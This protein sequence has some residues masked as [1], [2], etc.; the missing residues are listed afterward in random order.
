M[1]RLS[2]VLFF[3]FLVLGSALILPL[4]TMAAFTV[5]VDTNL[6]GDP[7]TIPGP[8]QQVYK[9]VGVIMDPFGRTDQFVEGEVILKSKDVNESGQFLQKWQG[10]ILSD[11]TIPAPSQEF[12][13]LQRTIPESN[14][15]LRIR[16][17]S[18]LV[19]TQQI[20]A[21]GTALGLDGMYKCSSLAMLQLFALFLEERVNNIMGLDL[22]GVFTL[23]DC[24]KT[25]TQEYAVDPSAPNPTLVNDGY[26]D[27]FTIANYNDPNISVTQAWQL[28]ELFGVGPGAVP[29]CVIDSGFT[30]T[31]DF[32]VFS[33]YDFVDDDRNVDADEAGYHGTRTL[34]VASARLDDQF[35]SAGT[36]GPVALPMP[37]RFDLTYSQGAR[38]IRT[39][40]SWG[41]EVINNSWGG[42]CD[43][44]CDTFG[45]LSGENA[46]NEALD[47][48]FDNGVVTV[49]AAGNSEDNLDDIYDL[50]SEGGAADKGNIV[51]GAL[52][53]ATKDSIQTATHGWG[54][55]FGSALD[56]WIA[57]WPRIL[58]TPTPSDTTISTIGRTSGASAYTAGVVALMKALAPTLT[59][60]EVHDM[61]DLSNMASTDPRVA[62]GYLNVFDA[63]HRAA[64][65]AGAID[66]PADTLEP[67]DHRDFRNISPGSYCANLYDGDTEDGYW[68]WVD[69]IRPVQVQESSLLL[70]NYTATLNGFALD[71]ELALP[72]NGEL[73]PGSYY[74]RFTKTTPGAAF[75]EFDLVIDA[76]STMTPDRFE[77]NDTLATAA[78]LT[79][80][81]NQIGRIWTI[82]SLNFHVSGDPDYF[83]LALPSLPSLLYTDRITIWV[84]P[85]ED[86]Y[87][88][89]FNLFL[90]DA[91]GAS[92]PATAGSATTI[93]NVRGTFTTGRIRFLVEDR[94]G[95]RNNY[96]ILIGYDQYVR[97]IAEPETFA[98]PD[99]PSWMPDPSDLFFIHIPELALEGLA[100]DFPYPSDPAIAKDIAEGNSPV[101]IPTEM[102]VLNW[103]QK[104]DFVME[105]RYTG[106]S[107]DM[108]FTL[109]DHNGATLAEATDIPMPLS[110]PADN[111][112]DVRKRI[113]IQAMERGIYGVR[114]NGGEKP[115][116]YSIKIEAA[117]VIP[118][119]SILMFVPAMLN[120]DK[121][122]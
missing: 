54:S 119:R 52:D 2:T 33:P 73:I 44:W 16:V 47:E 107:Q 37:F 50:P 77:V 81:G 51:V 118:S 87:S 110:M 120:G 4:S 42:T 36:G 56:T 117:E 62:S 85:A 57:V 75:Y 78:E 105:I 1:N 122:E 18:S 22:N 84:E 121:N 94:M 83:D 58:S 95:R 61:V 28:T 96:R 76:P 3:I 71:S 26:M 106:S 17:N 60:S 103:L 23:R 38:A 99:I 8:G 46:L 92:I 30:L 35:G 6:K 112:L 13:H 109:I 79:L 90:Y 55:S 114:V 40:T 25:N 19:D 53:L 97:G 69:D 21:N 15:Y 9:V 102:M 65:H 5:V 10:V 64:S 70:G 34:S 48:A 45:G 14:G 101:E 113:E 7:E 12:M 74:L 63:V 20:I 59:V 80:P 32:P 89:S 29:L 88:S 41:A 111:T 67:N 27:A 82:D 115:I 93:E 24:Y 100:F 66:P 108:S 98:F 11:G 104:R 49:A 68:F 39:A 91:A 72:F 116:L 86:G 31:D 43:W